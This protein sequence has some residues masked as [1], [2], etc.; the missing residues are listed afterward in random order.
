MN[1]EEEDK[2][3]RDRDRWF[4][5]NYDW[6][7]KQVK[8]NIT[9]STGPMV[10]FHDDLI[11]IVVEQFLTRSLIQQ[12]QMLDDNVVSNYLLVSAVRHLQSSTSP[13]YNIV[14]KERMKSRSGAMPENSDEDEPGANPFE[15]Y[16]WY[17]CFKR[18]IDKMSFYHRQLLTDK[19]QDCL[20]FEEIQKKYNITKNSLVHDIKSA[21]QF[22][23]CRC[24]NNCL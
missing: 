18:E 24:D 19:Y 6:F 2:I 16:D 11:Q 23:R 4:R 17:Q 8:K 9:K 12:K 22:L 13:F 5:E 3:I 10:Q 1:K 15:Q 21:L 20:T 14:R 7:N